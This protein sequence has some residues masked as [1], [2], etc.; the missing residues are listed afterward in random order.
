MSL[1]SLRLQ[2]WNQE[3]VG[4]R[5]ATGNLAQLV[6]EVESLA[7]FPDLTT[8]RQAGLIAVFKVSDVRTI[9]VFP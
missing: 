3:L 6:Y 8:E 4:S 1:R 7:S 2:K 5:E 9:A